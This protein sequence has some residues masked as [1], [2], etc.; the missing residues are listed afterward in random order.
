MRLNEFLT[1]SQQREMQM[2]QEGP[3]GSLVKAAGRG[4]GNV[5]GGVARTAG[6]V[7]GAVKG[8]VARAKSSFAGGE[9]DAYNAL[10]GKPDS[11]GTAPGAKPVAGDAT[12]AAKTG[13]TATGATGGGAAGAAPDNRLS[14][15]TP[16]S[17]GD[18]AAGAPAAK[19]GVLGK[20][21]QAVKDFKKG[22]AGDDDAGIDAQKPAAG[23]KGGGTTATPPGGAAQP[24]AGD[25]TPAA[26]GGTTAEP[27]ADEPQAAAPGAKGAKPAAGKPGA[28]AAND[29]A[30]A[31]AQKAVD[32][33]PPEQKKEVIA[34]LQADPKV[35]AAMARPAAGTKE[36]PNAK[37]WKQGKHSSGNPFR[38]N[39]NFD[40]E[41]GEPIP[42]EF[43]N[44]KPAA[45]SA[46][47][48]KAEP[49]AKM[50]TVKQKQLTPTGF[51]QMVSGLT[52]KAG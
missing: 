51:G 17:G 52:K 38:G 28:S 49:T 4:V 43:K 48:P 6:S 45:K 5:I 7:K 47:K 50:G 25:E 36:S 30:Y 34:M 9:K 40:D 15:P 10:A 27:A 14:N 19:Q 3:L 29:S 18:A 23:A 46:A 11:G 37:F 44:N 33:L 1:E 26:G 32:G 12:P 21:G 8:A 16:P 35:K 20:I 41:T 24:A 31:Q 2:L 42:P 13:G 22:Y 39:D